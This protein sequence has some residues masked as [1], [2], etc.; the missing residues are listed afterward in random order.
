MWY[1]VSSLRTKLGY[2][3]SFTSSTVVRVLQQVPLERLNIFFFNVSIGE[4][5]A[6]RRMYVWIGW[7]NPSAAE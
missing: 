7:Q 4:K 2:V 5:T 6:K 3:R 1:V